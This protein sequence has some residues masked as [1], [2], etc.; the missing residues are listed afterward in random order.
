MRAGGEEETE[1]AMVGWHH[2]LTAHEIE[3]I[4]GDSAGQGSF[5]CCSPRDHKESDKTEQLN[6]K[7]F[8]LLCMWV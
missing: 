3:Q 8:L 4:L 6:N 7:I 2:Q 1:D 5:A